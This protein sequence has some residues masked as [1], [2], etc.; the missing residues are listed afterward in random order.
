MCMWHGLTGDMLLA[1]LSVMASVQLLQN[2]KAEKSDSPFPLL[3]A[4]IPIL[5]DQSPHLC[6]PCST[7]RRSQVG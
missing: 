3:R 7:P 2:A 4:Y 1:L 5:S 6:P